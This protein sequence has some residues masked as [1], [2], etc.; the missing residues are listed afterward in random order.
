M[1]QNDVV[2]L[3][4]LGEGETVEFKSRSQGVAETACAMANTSGGSI[5]VGVRDDG[6]VA[7]VDRADEERVSSALK[8]LSP[9]PQMSIESVRFDSRR[10]IAVTVERMD[11][12]VALGPVAYIRIGRGNRPLSITEMLQRA[13]Q[14]GQL[15]FDLHPS[16]A[17]ADELDNVL[18]GQFL[19]ERERLRGIATQGSLAEN[20][21]RLNVLVKDGGNLRLSY[22][23]LLCFSRKPQEHLSSAGVRVVDLDG[24]GET[25]A[26][27]EFDGPVWSA[28]KEALNHVLGRLRPMEL[29]VGAA[30]RR[31]LEYPEWP[32]REA[33]INAVA[34]RNYALDA[35][36]RIFMH[37]D[38]LVIRSPGGFPPGV[39]PEHPEHRP[40]NPLLC[41]YLYDLGLIEKYGF[42]I[43][44]MFAETRAHPFCKLTFS[45]TPARVDVVFTKTLKKGLD[46][47]DQKVMALLRDG[48][49]GSTEIAG[50][51]LL[52]RVS[53]VKRLKRL[54]SL[55]LVKMSGRGPSTVYRLRENA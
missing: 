49:M 2:R 11:I 34:H 20:A 15:Q 22:A 16:P 9:P 21:R 46:D 30:R 3:I 50:A 36:T 32:V 12:L 55:G 44:N 17:R 43:S 27:R 26:I 7:G 51:I 45:L 53:A 14:L 4:R 37:P 42:G 31:I 40:V 54:V 1:D 29:R 8:A 25:V 38:R 23:G 47:L 24:K 35:D 5:L 39:T 52:S 19:K 28:A 10:V 6:S 13:V 48:P 41:Q 18:L 33:V